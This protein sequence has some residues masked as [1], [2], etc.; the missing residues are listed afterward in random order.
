MVESLAPVL[1]KYPF[2]EV[3]SYTFK[4]REALLL[5]WGLSTKQRQWL[6]VDRKQVCGFFNLGTPRKKFGLKET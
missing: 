3:L 4:R 5:L 1:G 2:L 6:L